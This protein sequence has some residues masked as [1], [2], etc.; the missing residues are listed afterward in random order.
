MTGLYLLIAIGIT[1]VTYA[2]LWI[3][4]GRGIRKENNHES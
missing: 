2:L 3:L 4:A 1:V